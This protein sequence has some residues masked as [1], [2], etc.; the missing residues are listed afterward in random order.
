MP[1][2]SVTQAVDEI[3]AIVRIA[4]LSYPSVKVIYE[5]VFDERPKNSP[6]SP[7][8]PP[9][10]GELPRAPLGKPWADVFVRH[11]TGGQRSIG[12]G[13]RRRQTHTGLLTVRVFTPS[14]D[15]RALSDAVSYAIIQAFV[16]KTTTGGVWFRNERIS[17]VG[18]DGDSFRVD[19]LIEFEYDV[20]VSVS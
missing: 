16:G 4:M 10:V 19:V 20:F 11:A 13:A 8:P 18:R 15:G 5:D 17:E 7:S 1:V 12:L 9:A 6:P 3:L 2:S 14:S